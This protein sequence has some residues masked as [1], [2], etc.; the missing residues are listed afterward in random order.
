MGLL[1]WT[2]AALTT[3][4][5]AAPPADAGP[6]ARTTS[7]PVRGAHLDAVDS[8]QGI[9]Y[10]Q[11]PTGELRWRAPV[12][13]HPW[14]A[15][16]PVTKSGPACA[17]NNAT[18]TS[19]DCLYLDVVAPRASTHRP[20]MVWIHGGGN[21]TGTGA[22]FDAA[23]MAA[24]GDVLVVT[25]NYRLG[26]FGFFG[27]PGLPDSGT[28]G[29]QDQQAALRWVRANAA[30]F[31]GDPSDVTVF[32]ESAGGVDVCAQLTSPGARGLFDRAIMQSGSCLTRV[33]TYATPGGPVHVSTS[34][35][36]GPVA[37]REA[38][39]QQVAGKVGCGTLECLRD[40]HF[41][42][43]LRYEAGFG[44]AYG[45][46]TLPQDPVLALRRGEVNRV[47]VLSG[48]TRDEARLTTMYSE[49]LAGPFTVDGYTSLLRT[50]FGEER[51]AAIEGAYPA[52]ADPGL[53]FA[54]MDTDRVFACPQL[55]TNRELARVTRVHGYEFA[56]EDA[57]TYSQYFGPRPPGAAHGSELAYLF[58]LRGG[59]PYRGTQHAELTAPQREL[60]DTMI[61]AWTGH[62]PWP[63][64]PYVQS[65]APQRIGPVDGWAEHHCDLWAD[66]LT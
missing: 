21:T 37:D 1:H 65:L 19:E 42:D 5:L 35:F 66:H 28:F 15:V 6:I 22:Q 33:P 45:T 48:N 4:G 56:D 44:P 47:P 12:P 34:G 52:G 50:T 2:L 54:T 36:W 41:E 58:D 20:V 10:A 16:R 14:S 26:V 24:R 59:A 30:A 46:P 13:P 53:A 43:L 51:A 18:G 3:L 17:Q 9:P 62:T 27:Y 7:G 64:W 60:G 63:Q 40:K 32:G 57:P 31:G 39:G 11:P 61:D 25:I 55:A 38:T 23:R 8:Y 29:L 49:L